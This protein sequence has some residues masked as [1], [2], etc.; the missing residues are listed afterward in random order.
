MATSMNN[1]AVDGVSEFHAILQQAITEPLE[2]S[3]KQ[4]R[5]IINDG[6]VTA[7]TEL[8]AELERSRNEDLSWRRRTDL[9]VERRD[10]Q[11]DTAATELDARLRQ[12]TTTVEA[13]AGNVAQAVCDEQRRQTEALLAAYEATGRWVRQR[14]ATLVTVL[15]AQTVLIG[16][17][18]AGLTAYLVTR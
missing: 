15:L 10:E 7:V 2:Q 11:A 9:A 8:R 4:V 6:V 14:S 1:D 13:M 17:A 16:L 12:L 5:S 3:Y 18:L